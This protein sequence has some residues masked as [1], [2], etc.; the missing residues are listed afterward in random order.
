MKNRRDQYRLEIFRQQMSRIRHLRHPLHS[1]AGNG[2]W[3]IPAHTSPDRIIRLE[4]M[5]PWTADCLG[6]L[7]FN[8]Q[9]GWPAERTAAETRR[10]VD[11]IRLMTAMIRVYGYERLH[12]G[13]LRKELNLGISAEI[14]FLQK[15]GIVC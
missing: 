13:M 1:E 4:A 9:N 11:E 15:L 14:R 10:S 6:N 2:E 3:K 8:V 7:H 12:G 5:R